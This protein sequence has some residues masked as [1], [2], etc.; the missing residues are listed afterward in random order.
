MIV[1][2]LANREHLYPGWEHTARM[3]TEFRRLADDVFVT[4]AIALE[5]CAPFPLPISPRR[6]RWRLFAADELRST[7]TQTLIPYRT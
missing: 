6:K 1:A 3:I 5:V 4:W 2:D 7:A